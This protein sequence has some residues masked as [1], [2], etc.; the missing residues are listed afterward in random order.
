MKFDPYDI[1][2]LKTIKELEFIASSNTRVLKTEGFDKRQYFQNLYLLAE[3]YYKSLGPDSKWKYPSYKEHKNTG[4]LIISSD[5]PF[6]QI[7]ITLE[8]IIRE[9]W[10]IEAFLDYHYENLIGFDEFKAKHFPVF[11]EKIVLRNI[12]NNSPF[13]ENSRQGIIMQWVQKIKDSNKS[14]GQDVYKNQVTSIINQFNL[15]KNYIV[16]KNCEDYSMDLK[17]IISILK[18]LEDKKNENNNKSKGR[19]SHFIE[20]TSFEE[21]FYNPALIDAYIDA[22]RKTD[23]PLINSEMCYIGKSKCA[24]GIWMEELERKSIIKH[25]NE[26]NKATL[27]NKKFLGLNVYKDG[28][29]FRKNMYKTENRYRQDLKNLI[30][31][32][33]QNSQK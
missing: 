29:I 30:S 4:T 27:L 16:H 11:I 7:G 21:L 8:L 26:A 22:L 33:S 1:N 25:T 28:S 5:N 3:Y 19:N 13:Q 32:I 12:R 9:D 18:K 6:F 14:V 2:I 23:P 15:Q 20:I 24:M 10:E 31:E 17:E